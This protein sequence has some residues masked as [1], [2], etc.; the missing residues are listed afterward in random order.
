MG[1]SSGNTQDSPAFQSLVGINFG[2]FRSP[3]AA[4]MIIALQYAGCDVD[5]IFR[6]LQS[7]DQGGTIFDVARYIEEERLPQYRL[8]S[9]ADGQIAHNQRTGTITIDHAEGRPVRFVVT[10]RW[11]E[12]LIPNGIVIATTPDGR[13]FITLVLEGELQCC[14]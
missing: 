3:I 6:V 9:C 7:Y 13:E 1:L 14:T 8:G 12:A 11:I 2:N 10:A 4:F 5:S